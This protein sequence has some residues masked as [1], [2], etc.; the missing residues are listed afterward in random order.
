MVNHVDGERLW[1]AVH[2]HV[3]HADDDITVRVVDEEESRRLNL[4]YRKKDTPTNVLTF[5][6]GDATHDVALCMSVAQREANERGVVLR[7][8]VALLLVHA[9]LHAVGMDHEQSA[10]AAEAMHAA[11]QVILKRAGFNAILWG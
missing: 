8:Y 11:E 2:D 3:G 6:Y 10:A 1:H 4:Q 9:F 5:S 7:D